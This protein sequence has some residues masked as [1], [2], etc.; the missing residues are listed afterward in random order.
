M[1]LYQELLF[2]SFIKETFNLFIIKYNNVKGGYMNFYNPY[3][4]S[5]PIESASSSIFSKLSLSSI[6]NGTSK[7]LNLVNQA[8]PVVKQISPIMK[9]VKTMF[10]VMNEF[11]KTEPNTSSTNNNIVTTANENIEQMTT[12]DGPTFFM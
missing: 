10:N 1:L 7:T 3:L 8:I 2:L 9:N 6:I 5:M 11:K 12:S 4:Y